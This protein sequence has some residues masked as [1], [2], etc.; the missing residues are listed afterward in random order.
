MA[1]LTHRNTGAKTSA[2]RPATA[3]KASLG[4]II[5]AALTACGGGGEEATSS[6][7]PAS[8]SSS[9]TGSSSVTPVASVPAPNYASREKADVVNRLNNDRARCGFGKLAQNA[10]L[11]VAAQGHAD[12]LAANN[13]N[14]HYQT[15]GNP[16]F[17]GTN[18]GD[19][20]TAAGYIRSSTGEGIGSTDYGSYFNGKPPIGGL[21]QYSATPVSATN[22]L[23]R[24]YATVYHLRDLMAGN[25]DVGVGVSTVD[26]TF[27]DG[28]ATVKRLVINTGVETGSV[29]QS[30]S[31]DDLASFPCEGTTGT[32][33]YFATELP[34]PFPSSPD[35]MMS[36]YGQP[37][38]LMS[39]PGTTLTVSSAKI[40]L[41]GGSDVPVTLLTK[42]NDPNHLLT[43]NQVFVVPTQALAEN[44]TYQVAISGTSSGKITSQNPTGAF[45]LSFTFG[46]STFTSN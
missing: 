25:R 23:G 35:R 36:P 33:P 20:I 15:S 5:F 34:D 38:Y 6:A 8:S 41:Q 14:T 28:T 17:T 12:Y 19:R 37:V 26:T 42:A 2:P 45:T 27:P 31:T 13:A 21:P 7:P 10:Q 1:R 22:V 11:D 24:L 30:I 39:G 40:K 4:A 3:Y 32:N 18:P 44:A 9:T 43:D 46:T 29:Q 16:G